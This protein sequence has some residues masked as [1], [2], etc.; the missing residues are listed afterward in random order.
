MAKG[1]VMKSGV[2]L[3]GWLVRSRFCFATVLSLF[4]VLCWGTLLGGEQQA[5]PS[6]SMYSTVGSTAQQAHVFL[7][8]FVPAFTFDPDNYVENVRVLLLRVWSKFDLIH[9]FHTSAQQKCLFS[10]EIVDDLLLL[11]LCVWMGR[12]YKL[13]A[14][15]EI[16]GTLCERLS[17]ITETCETVF[18]SALSDEMGTVR[19]VMSKLCD[20]LT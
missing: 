20:C 5:I 15:N 9:A 18:P 12:L 10:K 13:S 14:F 11:Y 3:G 7:E 2:G 6:P 8:S 19:H 4:L 17:I 16:K 1:G